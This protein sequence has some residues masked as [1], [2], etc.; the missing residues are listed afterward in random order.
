MYHPNAKYL[1]TFPRP[2]WDLVSPALLIDPPKFQHYWSVKTAV[3]KALSVFD[4][5]QPVAA[6]TPMEK[7]PPDA[8][9]SDEALKVAMLKASGK[10]ELA[11]DN[12]T[13]MRNLRILEERLRAALTVM[14]K[15]NLAIFIAPRF[16]PQDIIEAVDD[17]IQHIHNVL[18]W[19][20]K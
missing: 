3:A 19:S 8:E 6:S 9:K 10:L 13:Y 15:Y 18:M 2:G 7:R 17:A 16:W 12:E 20:P 5:A 11:Q 4:G 14:E 1:I